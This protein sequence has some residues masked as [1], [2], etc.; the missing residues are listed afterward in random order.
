MLLSEKVK[1]PEPALVK[2]PK[3]E[4]TPETLSFPE[5]PEVRIIPLANSTVPDPL[6]D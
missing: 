1:I 5:S 4:I 2:D 6:N 3:P